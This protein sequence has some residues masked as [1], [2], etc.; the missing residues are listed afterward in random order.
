MSK[1]IVFQSDFTYKEG[2]VA[3]MYGVVKQVD[4]DLEII[5][6]THEIPKFDIWSA[7]FR[8]HQVVPF[9]PK[10]T[11]FVSVVDPGVG[12]FR[13]AC[14][15]KT[16]SG[17]LVVTPDNKTLSHIAKFI[18]LDEVRE[19]PATLR[20]DSPYK[21]AVFH[22]RDVFGY[23]GALLASGQ[24]RFEDVGEVYTD[25]QTYTLEA[26]HIEKDRLVGIVEILDPNFGNAWTNIPIH[27][28]KNLGIEWDDQVEIDIYEKDRLA[29]Q[30]ILPYKATFGGVHE[31]EAVLYANELECFALA[32]NQGSF[33]D[34]YRIHQG[35]DWCICIK[36]VSCA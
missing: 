25:F 3:A 4:P 35:P 23:V 31:H 11:V 6:L 34:T 16:K 27:W 19:I 22:G 28:A 18:G 9:W 32:I 1:T 20:F 17:Q 36:K 12:T 13:K 30:L 10:G 26:P 15:A 21:T 29:L 7:S 24:L 2:A 5:D 8:L 14:V 33:I